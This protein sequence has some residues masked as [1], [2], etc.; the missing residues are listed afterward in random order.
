MRRAGTPAARSSVWKL[1]SIPRGPHMKTDSSR[2]VAVGDGE[3]ALGREAPV[4][5]GVDQMG[6]QRPVAV[7]DRADLVGERRLAVGAVEEV[8][9]MGQ[10]V[11]VERAQPAEERRD[12][13]A[14]GDPHLPIGSLPMAEAPVGTADDGRHAGLDRAPAAATCSRRA[15]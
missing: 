4:D 5:A 1:R 13:D 10:L 7:G 9:A 6:V 3:D 14:A 11:A 8:D 2:A 15:P 12:A